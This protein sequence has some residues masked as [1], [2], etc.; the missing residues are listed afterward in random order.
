MGMK[1]RTSEDVRTS[2]KDEVW[3]YLLFAML[4]TALTQARFAPQCI[5]KKGQV[6]S[7][8]IRGHFLS[9]LVDVKYFWFAE[10]S[11]RRSG[12]IFSTAQA[13]QGIPSTNFLFFLWGT[14]T[15]KKEKVLHET[16]FT[17]SSATDQLSP[18]KTK[19]ATTPLNATQTWRYINARV[20]NMCQVYRRLDMFP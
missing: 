2:K 18:K 9:K 10:V 12:V 8:L 6:H 5:G 16:D 4:P 3:F 19:K 20:R 15:S 1:I 7:H 17:C 13:A 11:K 14:K